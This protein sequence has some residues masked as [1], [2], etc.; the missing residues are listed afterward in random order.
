MA[1][2]FQT[3]SPINDSVFVERPYAEDA[4]IEAV[5]SKAEKA[6]KG[7]KASSIKERARACHAVIDY[8]LNNAEDMATELTW[9]MGRPLKYTP[10]EIT[11]GFKERAEYMIGIAE[12][13]LENIDIPEVEGFH[14]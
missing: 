8:F 4:M 6:K 12:G 13:A 5:L 3:I 9:Q 11:N 10:F 14:K 2:I 1:R 7:W